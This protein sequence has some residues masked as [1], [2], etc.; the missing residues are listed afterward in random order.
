MIYVKIHQKTQ[1]QKHKTCYQI[2]GKT[3]KKK[4]RAKDEEIKS[5]VSCRGKKIV[6]YNTVILIQFVKIFFHLLLYLKGQFHLKAKMRMRYYIR[7]QKK[8]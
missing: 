5:N 7:K 3:N 8:H 4:Y 1:N 2:E 6:V